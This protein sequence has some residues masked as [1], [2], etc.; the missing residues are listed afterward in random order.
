VTSLLKNSQQ[1]HQLVF[2]HQNLIVNEEHIKGQSHQYRHFSTSC[3]SYGYRDTC[4]Y[5]FAP[6]CAIC[7]AF[8]MKFSFNEAS[9]STAYWKTMTAASND[10]VYSSALAHRCLGPPSITNR[11]THRYNGYSSDSNKKNGP[12]RD[13]RGCLRSLLEATASLLPPVHYFD[14]PAFP[15]KISRRIGIVHPCNRETPP[16]M[17]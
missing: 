17:L 8:S 5:P 6:S 4:N 10:S 14:D 13:E 15:E 9:T 12:H 16:C 2:A 11:V 1:P 3:H 7:W